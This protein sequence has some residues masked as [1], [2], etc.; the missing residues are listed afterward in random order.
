MRQIDLLA[1]PSGRS[2][3]AW[4]RR[5]WT[6]ELPLLQL[7]VFRSPVCVCRTFHRTVPAILVLDASK[8]SS[9]T[10]RTT[11]CGRWHR[12][13]V[14]RVLQAITGEYAVVS[15]RGLTAVYVTVAL[16]PQRRAATSH[17]YR[18][19]SSSDCDPTPRIEGI[20]SVRLSPLKVCERQAEG[21]CSMSDACMVERV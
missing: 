11:D 3:L 10:A 21:A 5:R 13:K 6:G 14:L 15:T 12:S 16:V 2:R 19:Q 4:S 9:R 18:C 1:P 20:M 8:T 7:H 17:R